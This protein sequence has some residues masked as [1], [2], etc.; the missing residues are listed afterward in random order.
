MNCSLTQSVG[1][2]GSDFLLVELAL[3]ALLNCCDAV[4]VCSYL[5]ASLTAWD[6]L[7]LIKFRLIYLLIFPI[8]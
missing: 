5:R 2:R 7:P 6:P 1:F 8:T 3:G 4:F